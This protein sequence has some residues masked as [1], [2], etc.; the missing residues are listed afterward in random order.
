M[1][2][3]VDLQ[4]MQNCILLWVRVKHVVDIKNY[5]TKLAA[6]KPTLMYGNV[7]SLFDAVSPTA[8]FL[9]LC[10]RTQ[11]GRPKKSGITE[12]NLNKPGKEMNRCNNS[13]SR[14]HVVWRERF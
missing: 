1:F 12:I 14:T 11:V 10:V 6:A 13:A 9:F 7:T 2:S 4:T 3:G 5:W 8:I